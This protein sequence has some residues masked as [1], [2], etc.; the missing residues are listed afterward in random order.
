[1]RLES[2]AGTR[3]PTLNSAPVLLVTFN[4]SLSCRVYLT[5]SASRHLEQQHS[6]FK[7]PKSHFSPQR[8]PRAPEPGRHKGAA[9]LCRGR[10]QPLPIHP[11]RAGAHP[12][13][14]SRPSLVKA[15]VPPVSDPEQLLATV[16]QHP[17]AGSSSGHPSMP[18]ARETHCPLDYLEASSLCIS[19]QK[20]KILLLPSPSNHP[21]LPEIQR[22]PRD[23]L[24]WSPVMRAPSNEKPPNPTQNFPL[25]ATGA[26]SSR[27]SV[28]C[29]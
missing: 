18:S 12:E 2:R 17:P 28:F 10:L 16:C 20:K 24:D 29:C 19:L 9:A 23:P 21:E 6:T 11:A 25:C 3:L 15:P 27:I 8:M 14:S 1:M 26:K 22:N 7:Q 4:F 5:E 13:F